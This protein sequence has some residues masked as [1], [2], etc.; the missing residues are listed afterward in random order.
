[1]SYDIQTNPVQLTKDTF[2]SEPTFINVQ[3]DTDYII[4][5]EVVLYPTDK[6]VLNDAEKS[7]VF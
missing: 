5:R 4:E 7:W 2:F 1:M 3:D 6:T